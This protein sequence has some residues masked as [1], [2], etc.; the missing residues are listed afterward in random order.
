VSGGGVEGGSGGGV[1][2]ARASCASPLGTPLGSGTLSLT[3]KCVQE[4]AFSMVILAIFFFVRGYQI[5]KFSLQID[6]EEVICENISLT[7]S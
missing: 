2:D 7:V 6:K 3:L 4:A 1:G 5:E